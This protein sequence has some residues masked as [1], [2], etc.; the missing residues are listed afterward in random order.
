MCMT[1][2]VKKAKLQMKMDKKVIMKMDKKVILKITHP[3]FFSLENL[4]N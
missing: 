3:D 1:R 4:K 2:T